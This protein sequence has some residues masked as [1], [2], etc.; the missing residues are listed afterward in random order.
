MSV[1]PEG[2]VVIVPV[3]VAIFVKTPV[4]GVTA[5]IVV[6]LIVLLVMFSPD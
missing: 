1:L 5:P 3:V 2:S 6:L 4:D